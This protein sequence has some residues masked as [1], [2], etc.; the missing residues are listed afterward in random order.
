L[1]CHP[2][3]HHFENLSNN[4]KDPG[5]WIEELQEDPVHL[6]GLGSYKRSELEYYHRKFQFLK[7]SRYF[8]EVDIKKKLSDRLTADSV[9]RALANCNQLTFEVTDSCN[10]DCSYCAYGEFYCDY[11][12]RDGKNLSVEVAKRMLG[13]LLELWNS[14]LNHSHQKTIYISFYG[15]E[16]LLNVTFIKE[17][18][19][20]VKTLKL[21]HNSFRFSMTTNG[22][23]LHKYMDLLVEHDFH[24]LVSLD[25]DESHNGYR[26][27]KNGRPSHSRVVA[28]LRLFRDRYPDFFSRNLRFNS[29]LHNRN[30]ISAIFKY[31][32]REFNKNPNISEVNPHGI[33]AGKKKEF[34][35]TYRNINENL[36]QEE[37][38]FDDSET[39]KFSLPRPREVIES[40]RRYSGVVFRKYDELLTSGE[41]RRYIPTGT[42][43]PFSRMIFVTVNGKI[44]PCERIGHQFS[45]GTVTDREI[46][47]DFRQVAGIYNS[48]YDRLA[49]QCHACY[50]T[51]ACIQC[52]FNLPLKNKK[53][54]C[55]GFKNSQDISRYFS[56]VLTYLEKHPEVYFNV[57]EEMYFG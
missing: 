16:P 22:L 2:L 52:L 3:I 37:E 31:F 56:G 9:R 43:I 17:I 24:L 11:D 41:D 21:K 7:D 1:L 50:N 15:G 39:K 23:L 38:Y 19:D 27:L 33:D 18:I 28:N 8:D 35:E 10:L 47:L 45:L 26:V 25:G 4:S 12:R 30:S 34:R 40:I 36:N 29:V 6:E 20:Y 13:Y 32:N 14:S 53:P 46:K 51:D 44:L 49:S 5:K 42:C 57:M 54:V 48:Y 55:F